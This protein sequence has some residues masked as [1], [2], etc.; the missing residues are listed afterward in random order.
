MEWWK[1]S[2][3]RILGESTV[4]DTGNGLM[5]WPRSSYSLPGHILL[6]VPALRVPIDSRKREIKELQNT[7]EGKSEFFD[8]HGELSLFGSFAAVAEVK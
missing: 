5:G 2:E 6:C 8:D 3:G 7:L 1:W 4:S